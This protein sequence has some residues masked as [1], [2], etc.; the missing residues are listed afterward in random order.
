MRIN[1]NKTNKILSKRAEQQRWVINK[2]LMKVLQ[3]RRSVLK[4][5][6]RVLWQT[7][8]S[9][10]EGVISDRVDMGTAKFRAGQSK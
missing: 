4:K 8:M 5:T 6:Q 10:G 3:V 7:I 2:K 9:R 1:K